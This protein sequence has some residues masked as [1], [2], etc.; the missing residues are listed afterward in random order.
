MENTKGKLKEYMK[1]YIKLLRIKHY[2]KSLL[3]FMPLFFAGSFFNKEN[4]IKAVEGFICF[5]L[6]SSAVYI[7][8]DYR[9]IEKDKKHPTKCNRPLASGKIKPKNAIILMTVCL[10]VVAIMSWHIGNINAAFFL[11]LYFILN[12]A[13][14]MG[15]KNV[16]IIDVVIL[17]SGFVIRLFYGGYVTGVE[18]SKCLYLV[19]TTGSLYM[20]LGKRRNEL[21]KQ[22]DTREVL[23]YY[24]SPFL[25]KNMYVCVALAN[26]FYAL[27]TV[28]MNNRAMI[29]TVPFFMVILMCYSLDAEGDSDGDPVE[30]I[31]KDKILIGLILVYAICIFFLIYV[32]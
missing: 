30:V 19:V 17:A 10:I 4:I 21:K 16:P 8:N 12:I 3:I 26:V 18:I 28:E 6:I 22:L 14:S 32:I 31:L 27:W 11:I 15:L 24:N 7:L 20:G 25:D 1:D 9:D 23:K 5:C 29:W 2:I 13:Y